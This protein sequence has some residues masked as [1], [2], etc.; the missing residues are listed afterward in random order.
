MCTSMHVFVCMYVHVYMCV[1]VSMRICESVGMF[2]VYEIC[3]YECA[4]LYACVCVRVC[5]KMD[6][7]KVVCF[8]HS[9]VQKVW[10]L[11]M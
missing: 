3:V 5:M 11:Y 6:W 7:F 4:G 1:Y 10:L 2:C 8:T 9:K